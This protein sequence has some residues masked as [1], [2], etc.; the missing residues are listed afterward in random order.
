M[1][2]RR[3]CKERPAPVKGAAETYCTNHLGRVRRK[4]HLSLGTDLDGARKSGPVWQPGSG[5]SGAEARA[6]LLDLCRGWKPRPTNTLASISPSS[7]DAG[8][9]CFVQ[10]DPRHGRAWSDRRTQSPLRGCTFLV[11]D[12][13]HSAALRAGLGTIAAP[14]LKKPFYDDRAHGGV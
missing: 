12:T 6:L 4:D 8:I 3:L 1:R 2:I 13:R 9:A 10:Q 14:R 7:G 11:R 5:T